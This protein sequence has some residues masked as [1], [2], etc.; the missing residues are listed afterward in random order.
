MI[1]YCQILNLPQIQIFYIFATQCHRSFIF[2]TLK[3]VGLSLK[4]ERSFPS[5]S[6]IIEIIKFEIVVKNSISLQYLLENS[7]T[8]NISDL[9]IRVG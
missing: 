7:Y 2:Q 5:C 6:K 8:I 9:E 1:T 4:S 3:F